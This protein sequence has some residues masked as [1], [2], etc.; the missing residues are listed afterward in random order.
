MAKTEADPAYEFL[1]SVRARFYGIRGGSCPNLLRLVR[2]IEKNLQEIQEL[3]MLN[4]SSDTS[5]EI[6]KRL[7]NIAI[8]STSAPYTLGVR[9][10]PDGV[11]VKRASNSD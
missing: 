7:Q 4:L 3:S 2:G 10:S 5:V 9:F 6:G 8:L 11:G 1:D